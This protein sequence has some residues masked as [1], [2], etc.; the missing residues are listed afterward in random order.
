MDCGVFITKA[1]TY[2]TNLFRLLAKMPFYSPRIYLWTCVPIRHTQ[3]KNY[4]CYFEATEA[5]WWG[6]G[7]VLMWA[8]TVGK[9]EVNQTS[10]IHGLYSRNEKPLEPNKTHGK[11][12]ILSPQK[13][14]VIYNPL[15]MQE[16]MGSEGFGWYLVSKSSWSPPTFQRFSPEFSQQTKS[17]LSEKHQAAVGSVRD[18]L[19]ETPWKSFPLEFSAPTPREKKGSFSKE[20]F[21]GWCIY[22]FPNF[23]KTAAMLPRFP[24]FFSSNILTYRSW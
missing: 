22:M 15:K 21:L 4:T 14:W 9:S 18:L 23:S 11:M 24:N 7:D 16:N 3:W 2:V 20:D 6:C 12:K 19:K 5:T 13:I 8:V 1:T 10:I 17:L